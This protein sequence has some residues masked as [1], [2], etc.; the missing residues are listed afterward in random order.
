MFVH[1]QQHIYENEC[2]CSDIV[3][4][5]FDFHMWKNIEFIFDYKKYTV[6][7]Y[8]KINFFY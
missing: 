7:R 6:I 8:A 5:K 2:L 4:E 1:L 3:F